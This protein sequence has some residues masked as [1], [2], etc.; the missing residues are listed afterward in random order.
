MRVFKTDFVERSAPAF[1]FHMVGHVL[2]SLRGV[3]G[4]GRSVVVGV[5]V[6]ISV[7]TY[8]LPFA[9]RYMQVFRAHH[10]R[11]GCCQVFPPYAQFSAQ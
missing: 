4:G 6:V 5:G 7:V 8:A 2:S 1:W 3:A 9:V 11:A 10:R